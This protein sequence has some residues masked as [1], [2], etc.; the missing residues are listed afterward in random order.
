MGEQ[1]RLDERGR[2]L[3]TASGVCF[4]RLRNDLLSWEKTA[5]CHR[6]RGR[7]FAADGAG[8]P[9]QPPGRENFIG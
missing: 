6:R 2:R 9:V 1:L 8:I 4:S 5:T 7:Q 3:E